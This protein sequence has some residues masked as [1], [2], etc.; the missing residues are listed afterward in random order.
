[1]LFDF[2]ACIN[3]TE[4]P[5]LAESPFAQ[6]SSYSKL[7]Y[8]EQKATSESAQVVSMHKGGRDKASY[9]QDETVEVYIFGYCFTKLKSSYYSRK[10]RL[11]AR[12]LAK[13]YK[14]LGDKLIHE[15]KGSFSVFLLDKQRKVCHLFTDPFNVRPLYYFVQDGSL[16]ISTALQALVHYRQQR[17]LSNAL[18]YPAI[19]EYYLFEYSLKDDTCI[20][21][22]QTMPPGGRLTFSTAGTNLQHYWDATTELN[23]LQPVYSEKESIPKLEK[24]LK[25]NLSLYLFDPE[26]TAVALTG[27]YDSR[28]NLALLG[29]QAKNHHFYS[30]GIRG[31]YDLSIPQQ[32][33]RQQQLHY[34]SILLD[35]TYLDHYDKYAE[36]AIGLGDGIAEANRANYLYV[37]H[38]LCPRYDYILTGLFGSELIKHPTSMGNF[39]NQDMKNLLLAPDPE[40]YLDQIFIKA[41]RQ[42]FIDKDLLK[43]YEGQVKE[44]V[45]S[46]PYIVNAHPFPI[47]YFYFLLML[48]IRKYFM[49]EIKVERAYVS[50]LHP[51]LDLEF[52]ELLLKTPFPWIYHWTG[53]KNLLRSMKTH[54]FYVSMIQR[55]NPELAWTLSTH[56]YTPALVNSKL[57]LPL[58]A[59][60][61]R[62]YKNRIKAKGSF[63]S[64]TSVKNYF[65]MQNTIQHDANFMHLDKGWEEEEET[66]NLIK[67]AS[68]QQWLH[69]NHLTPQKVSA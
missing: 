34:K 45:L 26:R 9:F 30:Y 11:C 40:Q 58:M 7:Q 44:R 59:L 17:Q 42:N 60:Q 5:V 49:K 50:N 47:K 54:R 21:S 23:E 32:I 69:L 31:T 51:F 63:N 53:K 56:G 8:R 6:L 28:L 25:D 27:G 43:E 41:K 68:L 1:M 22:I 2:F 14:E 3:F 19:I 24:L 64:I 67:L 18:N 37:F 48:G 38:Q 46:H 29:Y 52:V 57:M 61:Y 55:N 20:K 15:I 12:Q 16:C 13:A 65:Q 33:A 62:Y 4:Q 36:M 39:I 10:K 66:R 35:Q